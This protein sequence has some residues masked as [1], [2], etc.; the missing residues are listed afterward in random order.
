MAAKGGSSTR[1]TQVHV[2]DKEFTLFVR[3]RGMF[4]VLVPTGKYTETLL[5]SLVQDF[6]AKPGY[7]AVDLSRLDAVTLTLVKALYEF[8]AELDPAQGRLV[9]LNPPDRIRG[10]VK[11]VGREGKVTIIL[12]EREL[13]GELCDVDERIRRSHD[14]LH[15][16]RTMMASHPCWQLVDRESRWLCPFC[17]TLQG[18]VRFIARG[19]PTQTVIDCVMHHLSEECSTYADGQTDGW[20]F[21]VLGQAIETANAAREGNAV[22]VKE[23]SPSRPDLSETKIRRKA[24][25]EEDNRHRRMLPRETPTIPGCEIAVA[26]RG[27]PAQSGDFFDFVRLP[28]GRV[29]ILVGDVSSADVDAGVLMGVARKVLCIRL[30][31][32]PDPEKAL[33]LANDD[34]CEELDGESFVSAAVAIVDGEKRE[35]QIARAGHA[36][37]FLVHDGTVTRLELSGPVLG[38]VP[39]A[40]FEQGFDVRSVP[41]NPGDLLLLHTDGLEDLEGRGGEKFGADRVAG[42]LQKNAALDAPLLL[43]T[44]MLEAEQ[45]AGNA[46]READLTAI[47]LKVR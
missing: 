1:R 17:A 21:E 46:A 30:R 14:R 16:V 24:E 31:E 44:L 4:T 8:A 6:L 40:S 9:L 13:E 25:V 42:V 41:L 32:T 45:F 19:S 36:A 33:G 10:L 18:D 43:G 15:L 26:Y 5:G 47:C 29:G 38:F 7:L 11:L 23:P 28:G 35:L 34:L 2:R 12:S 3:K 22:S 39:T 37:P 20:P 27:A